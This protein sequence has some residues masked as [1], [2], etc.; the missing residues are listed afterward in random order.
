MVRLLA[1]SL[2]LLPARAAAAGKALD[3][4]T[5][6]MV[7]A[8]LKLPTEKLPAEH[9]PRF[10]AVDPEL[11]PAKLRRPFRA[12]RIELHTFRQL[13]D[14]K[15]KG[16]IRMPDE[17]CLVPKEATSRE[18]GILKMAG[19]AEITDQEERF[20][21]EQTK[22]T[23]HDLMCEFTLRII[24]DKENKI[25]GRRLFMHGKD[26]MMALVGTYRAYGRTRQTNFF[27]MGFPTCAPRL[28]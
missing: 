27:G 11:L 13:A 28:K 18:V 19:Y 6:A 22:C 16:N 10:L 3:G 15:K 26:P 7:K 14:G 8:F 5:L 4:D 2:L 24:I 12:K 9:V 25:E 23:E 21:I 20:L 17:N 1:L